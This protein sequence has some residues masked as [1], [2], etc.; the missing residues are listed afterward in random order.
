MIANLNIPRSFSLILSKS[1]PVL[2]VV[3]LL[4]PAVA[5]AAPNPGKKLAIEEEIAKGKTLFQTKICFTCHQTDPK[6]PSPAGAAM[7]APAFIGVFWGQEREVHVGIGGPLKK[8]KMDEEYFIE[9]VE[10]PFDKILKGALPGMAPLPTTPEERQALMEY[11]KS[12]S[13]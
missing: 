9:S 2:L 7:K 10:K 13:K 4:G 5:S 11:V 8:V 3:G 12:L 6:V 1:L